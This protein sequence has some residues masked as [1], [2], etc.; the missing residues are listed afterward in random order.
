MPGTCHIDIMHTGYTNNYQKRFRLHA[1]YVHMIHEANK[2]HTTRKT[3][4]CCIHVIIM[5][6]RY[7]KLYIIV[8]CP[9]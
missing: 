9:I 7:R 6:F 5:Q 4:Y 2:Y 1:S 8:C 3:F